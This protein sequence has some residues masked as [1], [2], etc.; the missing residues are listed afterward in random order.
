MVISMPKCIFIGKQEKQR[1][2]EKQLVG[3]EFTQQT[4]SIYKAEILKRF[5][6]IQ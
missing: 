3:T 5:H 6:Y 1:Y 2:N 4:P